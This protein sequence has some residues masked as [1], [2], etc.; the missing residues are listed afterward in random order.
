MRDE[1]I[2]RARRSKKEPFAALEGKADGAGEFF[3]GRFPLLLI[4]YGP[5]KAY[6]AS[7]TSTRLV[8]RMCLGTGRKSQ[9]RPVHDS[10]TRM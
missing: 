6:A 4:W 7:A 3:K 10:I 2:C 5:E 9:T 1:K 8:L